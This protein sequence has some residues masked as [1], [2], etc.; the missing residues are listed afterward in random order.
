MKEWNLSDWR[1]LWTYFCVKSEIKRRHKT[2]KCKEAFQFKLQ[3]TLNFWVHCNLEKTKR[4]RETPRTHFCTLPT[5]KYSLCDFGWQQVTKWITPDYGQVPAA[6]WALLSSVCPT[7]LSGDDLETVRGLGVVHTILWTVRGGW[8]WKETAHDINF[9]V[10][11][12]NHL[13]LSPRLQQLSLPVH[14]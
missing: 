5:L 6:L 12:K 2:G 3:L 11:L 4:K 14:P 9:F 8:K 10:D 1:T 13:E 7:Q